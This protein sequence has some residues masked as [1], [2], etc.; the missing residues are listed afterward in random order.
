MNGYSVREQF[1]MAVQRRGRRPRSSIRLGGA[2]LVVLA[3]V[4]LSGCSK[5]PGVYV[6]ESQDATA[7]ASSGGTT[8]ADPKAYVAKV[9]TAKVLPTVEAK[10][11]DA[12]ILLDALQADADAAGAKYGRHAGTG[13]PF[14]FLVKGSGTVVSVKAGS[15]G[16]VGVDVAPLDGKADLYLQLGPVFLGT[17]VRD[18][19]GFSSF[20]QF[21]NQIDYANVA[22]ALNDKVRTSVVKGQT[23][24]SLKGADV[25]FA[26]AFQLLDPANLLVTPVRLQV[27]A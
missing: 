6:V 5:V 23:P 12:R 14:S 27:A 21:V 16:Q 19:V 11:V 1:G 24:T 3:A 9:W 2:A 17:A 4:L 8:A 20:S 26:G 22:T 10:A 25:T 13:S 15:T 7:V 18:A